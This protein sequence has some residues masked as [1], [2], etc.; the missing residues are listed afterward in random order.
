MRPEFVACRVAALNR[1]RV[2]EEKR[3]RTESTR[4]ATTSTFRAVFQRRERESKSVV[5]LA[6]LR[7]LA[8]NTRRASKKTADDQNVVSPCSA[9]IGLFHFQ[10]VRACLRATAPLF[11]PTYLL[12]HLLTNYYY[13][14]IYIIIA[15]LYI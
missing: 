8:R 3:K 15:D 9:E 1:S 12:T 7:A 11:Y 4:Y 2:S 10:S 13:Y 6:W 5:C 14:Y